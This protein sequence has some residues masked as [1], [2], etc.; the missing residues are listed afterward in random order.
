[1]GDKTKNIN[2]VNSPFVKN[3]NRHQARDFTKKIMRYVKEMKDVT[4]AII[5]REKPMRK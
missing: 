5:L 1:M 2:S 4:A 3:Y